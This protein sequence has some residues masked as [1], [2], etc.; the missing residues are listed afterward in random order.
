[1][2]VGLRQHQIPQVPVRVGT[3]NVLL[4]EAVRDLG[5]H[6]DADASMKTQVSKTVSSSFAVPHQIAVSVDLLPDRS[7]CRSK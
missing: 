2:C 7:Y 6:L 4:P 1:V 5:I 3:D